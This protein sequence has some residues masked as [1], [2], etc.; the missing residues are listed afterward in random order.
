MK[1]SFV[2]VGFMKKK[3]KARTSKRNENK[4]VKK[5]KKGLSHRPM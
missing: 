5:N 4:V 2:K 3:E 1:A